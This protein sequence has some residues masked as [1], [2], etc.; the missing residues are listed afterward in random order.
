[1]EKKTQE[2]DP[3][4]EGGVPPCLAEKKKKTRKKGGRGTQ[5][6]RSEGNRSRDKDA[7]TGGAKNSG[8][9]ECRGLELGGA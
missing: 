8:L 7:R 4:K 9:V 1:V 6:A 2:T 5:T 3:E